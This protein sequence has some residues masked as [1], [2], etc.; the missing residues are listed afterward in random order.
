MNI[1]TFS[2][3]RKCGAFSPVPS[4]D[5]WWTIPYCQDWRSWTVLYHYRPKAT[6]PKARVVPFPRY[7]Q[8]RFALF[9]LARLATRCA[10]LPGLFIS[11]TNSIPSTRVFLNLLPVIRS[12]ICMHVLKACQNGRSGT[13]SYR[14]FGRRKKAAKSTWGA[15]W[16]RLSLRFGYDL[17]H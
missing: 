16:T 9:T 13:G 11:E 4:T 2:W 6:L 17:G 15:N 1:C 8:D 12:P 7:F 3:E 5:P 14:P 10:L